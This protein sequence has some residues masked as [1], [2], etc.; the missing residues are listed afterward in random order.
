MPTPTA[1]TEPSSPFAAAPLLRARNISKAFPGVQALADVHLELRAGEVLCVVGENGAGKST[2]MK[3]LGGI[4][5]PDAGEIQIDGRVVRLGSV[6]DAQTAGVTLIH[7][8]LNL[9]TSLDVASNI[10]LGR[11]PRYGGP[12]RLLDRRIYSD[13]AAITRRVGLAA[14]TREPVSRLSI[15]QQQLVEIAR[16]LSLSSRVL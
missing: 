14:S 11:E 9:A 8:E 2:L 5:T 4:Y 10:F 1:D 6:Q 15:G 7:Q 12:L 3:I 13:A 16:S